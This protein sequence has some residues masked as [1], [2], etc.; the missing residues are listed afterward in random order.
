ML[1]LTLLLNTRFGAI[2]EAVRDNEERARF[3]GI[4]TVLPRAAIYA[5]SA[6]VT[7]VAGLLST[8]NTGFVSPESLHWSLSGMALMMVVV[9]GFKALWGPALGAVVY[10]IFKDVVGDYATHWMSIFGVALIAVIVFSPTGI[11]GALQALW[12]GKPAAASRAKAGAH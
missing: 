9:G 11:A 8:L 1:L 6:V 3:I 2:T 5:L 7:A 10:F 12:S 4:S